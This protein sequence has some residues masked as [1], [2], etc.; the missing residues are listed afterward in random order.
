MILFYL[1]DYYLY[2]F[3]MKKKR[4]NYKR[5]LYLFNEDKNVLRFFRII[6]IF[7]SVIFFIYYL[8]YIIFKENFKK[9]CVVSILEYLNFIISFYLLVI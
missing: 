6:K 7:L 5:I 1:C 9:G 3:L 2:F 8:Y 4:N